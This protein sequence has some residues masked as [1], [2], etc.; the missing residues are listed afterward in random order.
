VSPQQSKIKPEPKAVL[1]A[2][3]F[4]PAHAALE[5]AEKLFEQVD[6][7]S[8]IETLA[9][10]EKSQS[11]DSVRLRQLLGAAHYLIGNNEAA[12]RVFRT[13]PAQSSLEWTEFQPSLHAFYR[14]C[15]DGE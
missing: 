13:C 5:K 1:Q 12:A 14:S 3:V 2:P 8:V 9:P 6:Y 4:D 15:A 10:H 7:E 11:T